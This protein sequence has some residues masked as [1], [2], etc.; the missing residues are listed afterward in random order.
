MPDT[1]AIPERLARIRAAGV[2]LSQA[3]E[4]R[5]GASVAASLA[6]LDKAVAGSLFDTEPLQFERTLIELSGRKD[7]TR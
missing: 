2:P 7:T 6:A 5:V 4:A 1:Y 3:D